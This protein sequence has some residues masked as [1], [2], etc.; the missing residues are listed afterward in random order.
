M[1]TKDITDILSAIDMAAE[2]LFDVDPYR[3]HSSTVKGVIRSML[4]PFYEVLQE[5]KKKS[6]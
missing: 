1:Q 2:K 3:E 4:H 5:K 6:K